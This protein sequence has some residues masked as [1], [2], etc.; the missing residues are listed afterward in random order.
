MTGLAA[1]FAVSVCT[2]WF[3]W[4]DVKE[5]AS[6]S[7]AVWI[8]LAWALIHSSRP[9]TEWLNGP[10]LALTLPGDRDAGSPVDALVAFS[11][12][13]AGLIVLLRRDIRF[14]EVIRENI[15]LFV[16]YAFWLMSISWSD[17]P[18]I[19][20]KRV[21]KDSGNVIMVLLIL[22][23]RDPVGTLRAVC[24][25]CAY[26][27]IPL[28]I[29]LIRYYPE[30]GRG[31]GGYNESHMNLIG[32]TEGKNE[33]GV[34]TL[35]AAILL[36][37]ELL[38]LRGDWRNVTSKASLA[39]RVLIL[40]MCWYL[41]MTVDSAT[42]LVCGAFGSLLLIALSVSAGRS[43]PVRLE[44]FG[45]GT[46]VLL[47]AMDSVFNIRGAL[48]ESLGRD[49][50]LTTR[51]DIWANLIGRQANPVVG[52][53]FDTFWAGSRL[54]TV[55]RSVGVLEAHNGYLET[56]LNGGVVGS[57]LLVALLV[58]AYWRIRKAFVVGTPIAN[59]RF[60]LLLVAIVYNWSEAS[61]NKSGL[62]WLGTVFAIMEYHARPDP[63][64]RRWWSS[65]SSEREKWRALPVG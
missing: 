47:W 14:P 55:G 62:L 33:L 19:T 49:M 28:S 24:V 12:I 37:W 7:A 18:L 10:H 35:V 1:L 46:V 8:V 26:L 32:V 61:F 59:I 48:V 4:R 30:W 38:Q 2:L 52:A 40:L 57:C 54:V 44:A 25:R 42:S 39:Y 17:Y 53:G 63:G 60:V 16:F 56:Y 11:L 6:V 58:S 45:L 23:A 29:V 31:F 43:D 3:C 41:L 21:F 36:T 50:T 15:W 22:T 9:V 65:E 51:T 34:L 5:R 27:C 13:V 64:Q 20:L